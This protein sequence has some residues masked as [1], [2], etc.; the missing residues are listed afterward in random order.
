MNEKMM[1]TV[2]NRTEQLD[3]NSSYQNN[4]FSETVNRL[5]TL[6]FA[7]CPVPLNS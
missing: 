6:A 7:Y 3:D 5:T 2:E 1:E 4:E